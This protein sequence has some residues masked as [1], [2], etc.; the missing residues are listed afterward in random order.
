MHLTLDELLAVRDGEAAPDSVAHVAACPAC[1]AEVERLREVQRALRSLPARRPD[2]D[3]WPAVR[4]RLDEERWRRRWRLYGSVAASI[5]LAVTLL[6]A[7]RGGLEA[8]HE[9]RLAT[10]TKALVAQSQLLERTLR[11]Y[12]ASSPVSGR[13]V[14]DLVEI[15]DRIAV[16]DARLAQLGEVRTARTDTLA[17]WRERVTLLDALV[18]MH[19]TPQDCIGL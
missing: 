6:A 12:Q 2:A 4:S 5:A 7:V 18:A 11:S 10:R 16:I 9:A 3:L 1:H 13:T 17:L 8:Y 15:E 14:S 19:A